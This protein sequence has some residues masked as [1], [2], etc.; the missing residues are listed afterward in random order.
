MS[1]CSSHGPLVT[2]GAV[3]WRRRLLQARKRGGGL[4]G[5]LGK[6]SSLLLLLYRHVVF[7]L[8]G[9]VRG[10]HWLGGGDG[11]VVVAAI[12]LSAPRSHQSKW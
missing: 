1:I 11:L 3:Y 5:L 9:S 12:C 7:L 8:R 6:S 2:D 4:V 10:R